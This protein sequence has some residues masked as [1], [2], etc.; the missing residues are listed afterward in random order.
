[1]FVTGPVARIP[2][3]GPNPLAAQQRPRRGAQANRVRLAGPA[4]MSCGPTRRAK[5]LERGWALSRVLS[6]VWTLVRVRPSVSRR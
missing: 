5:R 1:V 4:S 6:S 2:A 3:E